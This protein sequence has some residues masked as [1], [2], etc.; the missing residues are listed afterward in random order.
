MSV[1]K[2]TTM[3]F[4]LD[5]PCLV[6]LLIWRSQ[7]TFIGYFVHWSVSHNIKSRFRHRSQEGFME[8]FLEL[9]YNSF[10]CCHESIFLLVYHWASWEQNLHMLRSSGIMLVCANATVYCFYRFTMVFIQKVAN[11]LNNM[12]CFKISFSLIA[13]IVSQPSLP[14]LNG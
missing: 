4:L 8:C 7:D 14:C 5:L 6:F 11:F 13:F 12:W 2:R 1:K 9:M 3:R 10:R